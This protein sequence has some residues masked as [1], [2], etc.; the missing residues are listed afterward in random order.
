M[1]ALLASGVLFV[2]DAVMACG[3]RAWWSRSPSVRRCSRS[4]VR[5]IEAAFAQIEFATDSPL[6]GD[7]FEPSVPRWIGNGFV[8]SS[9]LGPIYP[10][11]AHPSN[12]RPWRTDR[13]VE[14]RSEEPPLTARIRSRHTMA[15]PS[16]VRL[17]PLPKTWLRCAWK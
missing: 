7:G 15:T 4:H 5:C 10:R 6:E 3:I 1:E 11:T 14:R 17:E 13:G 8:G 16:A 12:C 2:N 9:E